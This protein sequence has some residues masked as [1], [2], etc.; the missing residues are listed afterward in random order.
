M[1]WVA[2]VALGVGS[3]L[4]G[5]ISG[6]YSAKKSAE[7]SAANTKKQIEWERERA[8]NA[9]QWEV[10]D[11]M[12]AGINPVLTAGGSGATTSSISPQMP[13]TS[14]Y[15]TAGQAINQGLNLAM[16][17]NLTSAEI[18]K[19]KAE[20]LNTIAETKI[21]PAKELEI[22]ARKE[23]HEQT[24]ANK[25]TE[26][27]IQKFE[28]QLRQ[29]YGEKSIKLQQFRDLATGVAA[30]A[31]TINQLSNI[32]QPWLRTS[33]KTNPGMNKDDIRKYFLP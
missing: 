17:Q 15:Q 25:Y 27:E 32:V 1:P 12:K 23:L 3:A 5:A 31:V 9:H 16:Q 2:P 18:A 19:K 7:A 21:I 14:G 6:I 10:Q 28:Y 24:S 13:D 22:L 30:G 29:K 20:T 4:G 26:N 33:N 11:L 8:T